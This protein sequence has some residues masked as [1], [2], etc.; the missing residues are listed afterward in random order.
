[1]S[2]SSIR[3]ITRSKGNDMAGLKWWFAG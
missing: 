2:Q 1:M 3:H